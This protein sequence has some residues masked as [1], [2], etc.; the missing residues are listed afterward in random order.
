MVVRAGLLLRKY[1]QSA[2]L[3]AVPAAHRD[4]QTQRVAPR[5]TAAPRQGQRV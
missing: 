1:L 5:A 3:P 2:G 4:R